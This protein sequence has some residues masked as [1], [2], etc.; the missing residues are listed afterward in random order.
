MNSTATVN[1]TATLIVEGMTCASCA[2]RVEKAALA[3]AGVVQ[4]QVNLTSRVLRLEL[5]PEFQTINSIV[6]AVQTAGYSARLPKKLSRAS[7][8]VEKM[9][10]ASCQSKVEKAVE[11]LEGVER[12]TVNLMTKRLNLDYNP[13]VLDLA[14]VSAA[15][16]KAGYGLS[17]SQSQ[18]V[19][20]QMIPGF[21]AEFATYAT[22]FRWSLI[23]SLPLLVVAMGPMLGLTLPGWLSPDVSPLTYTLTQLVL[24][25]PV[26]WVGRDFY[27]VGFPHLLKG[28]PNMDSLI[29][30]GTASAVLFSLYHSWLIWQ[31]QAQF[32]HQLYYETAGVIITLILFGRLLEAL[33]KEKSFNALK[34]LL[35]LQSDQ[36]RLILEGEER[37]IPQVEVIEGDVLLVKSGETIPVDGLILKGKGAVNESMITGESLPLAKEKG[38][39]VIGGCILAEGLLEIQAT[40]VGQDSML[41]KMIHLVEEAQSSKAPIARLADLVASYF[42]PVVILIAILSG[43]YWALVGAGTVF[44]VKIFVAVLVIACPCALGLATPTA[45]LVG[46]SRG[47]HLGVLIKGGES[48]ERLSKVQ[49]VVL[50]KTGTLTLG[51]PEVTG[52]YSET[53]G[54]EIFL[55]GM[56]ANLEKG[57]EHLFAQAIVDHAQVKGLNPN[58]VEEI[59]ILPGRGLKGSWQGAHYLLGNESLMKEQGVFTTPPPKS[60][61][62][63]AAGHS[64]VYLAREAQL[65]GF[66]A[67]RDAPRAEA[68]QAIQNLKDLG[69]TPYMLTGDKKESA[70]EIAHEMGIEEIIAEVLPS[71]KLDKIRELQGQGLKVAMVG[72]GIND[73]PALTQADVGIAMGSGTEVSMESAQMV[74]LESNLLALARGVR[75]SRATLRNIKQNLFWAFGYNVLGIPLAAG[76]FVPAFGIALN[77]M[78]AALAMAFSSVSVVVNALRLNRFR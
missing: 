57:S 8:K 14:A 51:E 76:V 17:D 10:C 20:E 16:E 34:E 21:A 53:A 43:G 78:I 66:L 40:H 13:E 64:L 2:G 39:E 9:S 62:E 1:T 12:F 28:A 74:L 61:G 36:A 4:A 73:A 26:L 49:A 24:L 67:L 38:D 6:E 77:P 23:F 15:V 30:L 25:L 69:M 71:E 5:S 37:L 56:A 50:D 72:D 52:I 32:A 55:L 44:S 27:L 31:G 47:A 19:Q 46:T 70:R 68:K 63:M 3:Q 41:A 29:A 18:D 7:F 54:E 22:Q 58:P 11:G 35:A 48:L 65:L 60:A 45:I 59:E 75:L 42:V 33:S